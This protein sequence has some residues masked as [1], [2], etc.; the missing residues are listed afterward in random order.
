MTVLH[1]LFRHDSNPTSPPYT[2]EWKRR[3]ASVISPR[4]QRAEK[5]QSGRS[6]KRHALHTPPSCGLDT[7]RFSPLLTTSESGEDDFTM[8]SES[9]EFIRTHGA[10]TRDQFYRDPS[11]AAVSDMVVCLSP[12]ARWQEEDVEPETEED[13]EGE[14]DPL[15]LG[16]DSLFWRRMLCDFQHISTPISAIDDHLV[17]LLSDNRYRTFFPAYPGFVSP[18]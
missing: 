16:T 4:K 2:S 10:N 11:R 1:R 15:M 8:T 14:E 7:P 9:F 12:V 18:H 3:A 6:L 13:Q 17:P 5:R